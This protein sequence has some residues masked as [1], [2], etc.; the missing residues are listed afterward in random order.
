MEVEVEV[1][2]EPP[3]PRLLRAPIAWARP[4][5][6]RSRAGMDLAAAADAE[7]PARPGAPR[8]RGCLRGL[9]GALPPDVRR[10]AAELAALAGPVVSAAGACRGAPTG[11][12]RCGVLPS[13]VLRFP[14]LLREACP[15][16]ERVAVNPSFPSSS[17]GS[18]L[19]S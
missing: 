16:A 11:G 13:A 14:A 9:R 4:P 1:G 8:W 3:A 17:L 7:T 12:A 6:N 15:G 19:D 18:S 2:V 5:P 10:E